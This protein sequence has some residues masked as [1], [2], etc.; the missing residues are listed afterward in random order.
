MKKK[1]GFSLAELIVAFLVVAVVTASAVPVLFKKMGIKNISGANIISKNCDATI[2]SDCKICYK[3]KKCI[4]CPLECPSGQC[5]DRDKCVCV[6]C[7]KF[8][9]PE[10]PDCCT[11]C[12]LGYCTGCKK[13]AGLENRSASMGCKICG[14][15]KYSDTEKDEKCKTCEAGT[16]NIDEEGLL[17]CHDCE[18]GYYCT[19]G[20][21]RKV[22]PPDTYRNTTNAKKEA[23]CEECPVNSSTNGLEGRITISSCKCVPGY[24]GSVTNAFSC[25]ECDRGYYCRGGV[26][27]EACPK[28][29]Y[30]SAL[31]GKK[32][33]DC[34]GCPLNSTTKGEVGRTSITECIC[35]PGYHMVGNV[36]IS[37]PEGCETCSSPTSCT[38]C[39]PGYYY[40][41]GICSPCPK[42][43]W[44]PGGTPSV[45][46]KNACLAGTYNSFT[47]QTSSSSCF[48]CDCGTYSAFSGAASCNLCSAGTKNIH[49]GSKSEFAC[50]GCDEGYISQA[51]AC[52]CTK[53]TG[54]TYAKD[55]KVCESCETPWRKGCIKCNSL[56][57]LECK[58]PEYILSNKVCNSCAETHGKG[59]IECDKDKCIKCSK[60]YNLRSDKKGCCADVKD[61]CGPDLNAQF[62]P[63]WLLQVSNPKYEGCDIC[64][65]K[66]NAGDESS[67][68]KE[69][70]RNT[71]KIN[72][73]KA[74]TNDTC[75]YSIKQKCCW[76]GPT[77][78]PETCN[79]NGGYDGCTRTLC[80][81]WAAEYICSKLPSPATGRSWR[82]PTQEEV[83]I[84]NQNGSTFNL[85]DSADI[86]GVSR[87]Q[88]G[89]G[90][91]K[92][93][94]GE[95]ANN[96]NAGIPGPPLIGAEDPNAIYYSYVINDI[97]YENS[98]NKSA[99]HS[100][101]C[102]LE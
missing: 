29:T 50:V 17:K 89:N 68:T 84:I 73:L 39:K 51:G 75:N 1:K 64:L 74:G 11:R 32:K 26:M 44:C 21:N 85:C 60:G 62:V 23:D 87:C 52:G 38:K 19:G 93:S 95:R 12:N 72:M 10:C 30:R 101:R 54:A 96:C 5:L 35:D 71:L 90:R 41:S 34:E 28:D 81:Y 58:S 98:S 47:K 31:R 46:K 55:H 9:S 3:N 66:F 67:V 13:G 94:Y 22:C 40:N 43:H 48:K 78:N 7:S 42:G 80:N 4:S 45:A 82:M 70:L 83:D 2:G 6:N 53:C 24:Y 18:K 97:L 8:N 63:A 25:K 57:C 88:P 36:C 56:K 16:Y 14:A 61:I 15:G 37:C 69:Y 100:V 76:W 79:A 99:A 33:D 91:C 102:V 27:R 20:T 77:T 92:G 49:S 65:K 86:P 59:C